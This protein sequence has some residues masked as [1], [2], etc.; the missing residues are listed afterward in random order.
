MAHRVFAGLA[1]FMGAVLNAGTAGAA[2]KEQLQ[3]AV[4]RGI[5][6]LR[7]LQAADGSWPTHPVGA[8]ALVGLT[9]LECEIQ[10]TD[11]AVRQAASYLRKAWPEINDL[12]QTY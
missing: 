8:T 10:A 9:L 6:Y 2:D 12:H 11:P 1:A 5:L 7:N 3:Q 4:S